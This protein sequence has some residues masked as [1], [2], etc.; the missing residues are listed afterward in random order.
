LFQRIGQTVA[1]LVLFLQLS[2]SLL[3]SEDVKLMGIN[4]L[5]VVD[6]DSDMALFTVLLPTTETLETI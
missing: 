4:K 5:V 2:I 3:E 6:K 1:V